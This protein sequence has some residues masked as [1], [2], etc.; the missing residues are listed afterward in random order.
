[1]WHGMAK[2]LADAGRE[3]AEMADRIAQP[4]PAVAGR[5]LLDAL[6]DPEPE[7]ADRTDV[8][9]PLLFLQQLM[10]A[11][12]LDSW[13]IKADAV[14][15]HS[16]GEIA[17]ACWAGALTLEDAI[18]VVIHRSQLQEKTRGSGAM[19]AIGMPIHDLREQLLDHRDL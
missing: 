9:Q 8:V 19:A 4:M 17:A 1:Q 2:D 13:G 3:A 12:Q 6:R 18:E 16:V 11:A 5:P 14:C 15:G 7:H 10:L